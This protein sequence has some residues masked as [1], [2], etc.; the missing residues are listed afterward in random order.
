VI[1]R[2]DEVADAEVRIFVKEQNHWMGELKTDSSYG[3]APFPEMS[4]TGLST[5]RLLSEL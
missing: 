3:L 4:E 2:V 1:G 5:L